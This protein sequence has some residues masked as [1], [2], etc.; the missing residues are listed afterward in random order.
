MKVELFP[1]MIKDV[2]SGYADNG[3]NGVFGFNNKLNIRPKYQREFVY[4]DKQRDAV[5]E[6]IVKNFPLNVMYWAK[7][8]DGTFEV[9]DGQ[10]RTISICQYVNGDFSIA[11]RYFHNLT[12]TEQ[13][14]ILNYPL[15]VYVCEGNDKERLDWF[16]IINI[17]GEKLTDQELLNI[18]YTGKWLEDA[19]KKFSKS[20]C[21][22]SQIQNKY[23]LV[24]G[25]PIRQEQLETALEWISDGNVAK[26]MAI[27]QHDNN[28]N[29][30]WLYFNGVVE[31]VKAIFPK[32]RKE[33]KGLNWGKLYDTY[34]SK[35]YNTEELEKEINRLM[36]D[37]D[38]TNKK[39][40]F[41]YLLSN[42][43]AEKERCLSIRTFTDSQKR[44]AY[45]RQNGVCPICNRE[46][47]IEDMQG[48]HIIEWSRG[49]KTTLDNLQMVC[50]CCHK[51][52]TKRYVEK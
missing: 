16:K 49:G 48:D 5:I 38:V 9:L 41:E 51:E 13:Q 34:K 23:L 43:S 25:S 33:M 42:K 1:I 3:E 30:L 4:K 28:A 40:I 2:V 29:E 17:A 32:Y 8:E 19:K 39:G 26:Y 18:N 47:V 11:E 52:M 12:E 22:A 24:S 36:A 27:H 21:I 35:S 10:Q 50:K 31:W 20:A 37:D 44:T 14:A 45:E 6:T 7:N 46:F 15:M